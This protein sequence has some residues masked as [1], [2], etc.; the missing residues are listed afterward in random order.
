MNPGNISHCVKKGM[1]DAALYFLSRKDWTDIDHDLLRKL[2]KEKN[3]VKM[4]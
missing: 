3:Y 2:L 4:A 1:E